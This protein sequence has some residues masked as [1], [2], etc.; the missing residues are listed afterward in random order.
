MAK[1]AVRAGLEGCVIQA[2]IRDKLFQPSVLVFELLQPAQV[3]D[4]HPTV[5][6]LPT[7][8]GSFTDTVGT[9]HVANLVSGFNQLSVLQ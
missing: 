2:E 8:I 9:A 4:I 5:L 7:I 6:R 3:T 1:T